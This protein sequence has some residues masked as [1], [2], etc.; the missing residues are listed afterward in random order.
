MVEGL[1]SRPHSEA[2]AKRAVTRKYPLGEIVPR[3][4]V[5]S[6]KVEERVRTMLE[7]H[8]IELLDPHHGVQAGLDPEAGY[9]PILTPDL[10]LKGQRVAVEV[11][12]TGSPDGPAGHDKKR[13]ADE[14]RNRLMAE[15][16]WT[17]VRLRLGLGQ[18]SAIGPFDVETE[19]VNVTVAAIDA[20]AEAVR[21]AIAGSSGV[22]RFIPKNPSP[23][24][25]QASRLGAIGQ[26]KYED[27]W[28]VSWLQDSGARARYVLLD[29]GRNLY[30]GVGWDLEF[31]ADVGLDSLPRKRWRSE[32]EAFFSEDPSPLPASRFPWGSEFFTGEHDLNDRLNKLRISA[33]E[34]TFT[35]NVPNVTEFTGS[36]LIADGKVCAELH[37]EAVRLGWEV[38]TIEAC[39]SRLGEYLRVRLVRNAG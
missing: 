6:S 23:Q 13:A 18:G 37:P 8:G 29:G 39:Q 9:W 26:H 30:A 33:A 15:A 16:G 20:L 2:G 38:T 27:G 14:K 17:L 1:H 21:R 36:A 34:Y 22:I 31:V 3:K 24:R 5:H 25:K 7:G 28:Y 19:S 32:L 35:A 11:D 12:P 10:I 4:R